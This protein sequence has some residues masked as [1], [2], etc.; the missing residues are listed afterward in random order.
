MT[1][2]S[3]FDKELE[4]LHNELILMCSYVEQSITGAVSA[5]E[6]DDKELARE[7]FENDKIV[8]DIEKSIES[9]CLTLLMRQ[10]P[11]ARDLRT[12][13]TALKMVTDLERI[14]DQSQDI[15]EI[16]LQLPVGV[17]VEKMTIHIPLMGNLATQMVKDSVRA[18]IH[19][20]LDLAKSVMEQDDEV[21]ALFVK[22]RDELVVEVNTASTKV[23][24]A[25]DTM[26]IVKYLERI[27]DHAVN[28]AEWVEFCETGIHKETKI[29]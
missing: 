21:D 2:R 18:F 3:H 5:L 13:S 24:V 6:N 23:N 8:D 26:M 14:A 7:V 12:I 29:L 16:I 4:N 15:A 11:V 9:K 20:D 27:A 10:Q 19:K 1:Q 17:K 28:I 25:V 22:V